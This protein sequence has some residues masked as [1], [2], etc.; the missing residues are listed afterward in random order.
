MADSGKSNNQQ[1]ASGSEERPNTKM[2]VIQYLEGQGVTEMYAVNPLTWC[3]HLETVAP[4]PA[5]TTVLDTKAPCEKCG[6][7]TENWICLVCHRVF[8]SRFV[9]EHMVMHGVEDGHLMCLSYSDLSVWCYGCDNYLD[10]QLLKPA[11][12]AAHLHKFGEGLQ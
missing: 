11:K 7:T 1:G 3:P 12:N 8:C 5:D 6:N 4:L 9:N 10:H 2:E